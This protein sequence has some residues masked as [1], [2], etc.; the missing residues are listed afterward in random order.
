M[1]TVTIKVKDF[2]RSGWDESEEV[3]ETY[4]SHENR[5]KALKLADRTIKELTTL[6]KGDFGIILR[7]VSAKKIKIE[8]TILKSSE[9]I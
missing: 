6:Q 4:V 3:Y 5:D 2:K 1:F 9:D 7:E 8:E